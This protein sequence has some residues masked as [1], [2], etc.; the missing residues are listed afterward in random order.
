MF[1]PL[2]LILTGK[3]ELGGGGTDGF[4]TLTEHPHRSKKVDGTFF[5]PSLVSTGISTVV[6]SSWTLLSG[7]IYI[8]VFP[9]FVSHEFP[10][11]FWPTI[12]FLC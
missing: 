12:V 1:P 10:P 6:T 4:L 8:R 11:F 2:F 7:T 9:L 3:L 5:T